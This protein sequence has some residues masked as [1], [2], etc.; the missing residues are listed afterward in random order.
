VRLPKQNLVFAD[1]FKE[2]HA[3]KAKVWARRRIDF[4]AAG[5]EI[6][7]DGEFLDMNEGPGQGCPGRTA[8]CE[9]F[10][11]RARS[12]KERAWERRR[13]WFAAAWKKFA[14]TANFWT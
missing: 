5:E 7:P 2:E 9:A 11:G 6:R 1:S 13:T 3:A 4:A 10:Y 12:K 8:F 14:R